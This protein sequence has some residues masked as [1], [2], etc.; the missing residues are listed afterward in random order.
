MD[1]PVVWSFPVILAPLTSLVWSVKYV[2]DIS[3]AHKRD[4]HAKKRTDKTPYV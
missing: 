3:Q 1:E 4:I 2:F